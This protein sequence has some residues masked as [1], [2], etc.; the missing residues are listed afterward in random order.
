MY[1]VADR[2][3]QDSF[4]WYKVSAKKRFA[5]YEDLVRNVKGENRSKDPE[6]QDFGV[7][8]L[9]KHPVD[10]ETVRIALE[11]WAQDYAKR[12]VIAPRLGV[13]GTV[14][15]ALLGNAIGPASWVS[16]LFFVGPGL[17]ISGFLK[18]NAEDAK[19]N[20]SLVQETF[21]EARADKAN[22]HT[23]SDPAPEFVT[24]LAR[25]IRDASANKSKLPAQGETCP[26]EPTFE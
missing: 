24:D 1:L 14:I 21:L 26:A 9:N 12:Q 20:V 15:L 4:C 11:S 5:N 18:L 17:F 25:A 13:A 19:D 10:D 22:M 7:E 3:G 2:L 23:L 8:P 16:T 6:Q